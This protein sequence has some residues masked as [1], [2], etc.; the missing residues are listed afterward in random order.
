VKS[1]ALEKG[2]EP[3]TSKESQDICFIKGSS[4]VDF[5]ANQSGISPRPGDIV[6]VNGVRIGVHNGLHRYTVGQRRGINCPASEPYYVVRMD[7]KGNRLVVGFKSDLFVSRCRVTDVNWI[8][9]VPEKPIHV[10]TRI[11]YRHQAVSAMVTP[12]GLTRAN[13]RF[14]EPQMA[15]TP[16]QGA[17][18]YEGEV[19]V[20][21]GW[22]QGL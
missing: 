17:V 7:V 18:F 15:V 14:E 19:V 9:D 2:L 10:H 8:S 22:I 3:V 1:L 16:G 4:Y 11:R 20:G 13:V 6:T 5:L 12:S 21:C